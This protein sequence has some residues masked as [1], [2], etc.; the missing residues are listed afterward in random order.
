VVVAFFR[1]APVRERKIVA[2]ASPERIPMV[3]MQAPMVAIP[4]PERIPIIAGPPNQQLRPDLYPEPV[5]R[6]PTPFTAPTRISPSAYQ[7][8]G[9]LTAEGGSSSSAAPDRTILPLYGREIDPRR[10][11]WNYY[12]RTDGANPVQVPVRVGNRVCDDDT[13]GCNELFSNDS[14]HIPALGRSFTA[15]VYRKSLFG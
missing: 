4:G 15:T 5:L 14:V 8:V 6:T 7:Q 9:I 11:R 13:N 10:S 12:T 2:V 3:M 1:S